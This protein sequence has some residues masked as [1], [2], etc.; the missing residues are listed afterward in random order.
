MKTRYRRAASQT[1]RT[2]THDYQR[3]L[4]GDLQD[5]AGRPLGGC[6]STSDHRGETLAL[7]V[8]IVGEDSRIS[9]IQLAL[10]GQDDGTDPQLPL[11]A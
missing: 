4:K 2:L 9:N 6:F 11:P 10:R 7:E 8:R 5:T 3:I 1:A